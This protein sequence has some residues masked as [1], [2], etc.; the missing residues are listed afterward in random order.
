MKIILLSFFLCTV[1]L[2]AMSGDYFKQV[3]TYLLEY[4][5]F[6]IDVYQITYSVGE[7]YEEL[8]LDYKVDVAKKH[9][10]EGWKVGLKY[11]LKDKAYEPKA[12]WLYDHTVDMKKGDKFKIAKNNGTLEL[13][14]N[15]EFLGKTTDPMIMELAF[16]PWLGEKPV[17]DKLKAALL[18]K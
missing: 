4:S 5:I 17:D 14:K 8:L 13:T 12:Q 2:N 6:K 15:N 11:K 18:G 3:G 1:S 9:S 7:K 10:L 16:E